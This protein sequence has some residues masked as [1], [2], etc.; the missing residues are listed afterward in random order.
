MIERVNDASIVCI[1]NHDDV[2]CAPQQVIAACV[3]QER[4]DSHASCDGVRQSFLFESARQRPKYIQASWV[5]DAEATAHAFRLQPE[6]GS[7]QTGASCSSNAHA[8]RH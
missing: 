1:D 6:L 5:D 3:R 2:A 8:A 4:L 7:C